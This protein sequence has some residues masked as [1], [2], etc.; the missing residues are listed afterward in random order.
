MAASNAKGK[1][2]NPVSGETSRCLAMVFLVSLFQ[3]VQAY[4]QCPTVPQVHSGQATFYTFADG[5]GACMF[6]PT[7]NDLLVGAMNAIDY[8]TSQVCGECVSLTG[9]HAT[10]LIRIVDLCPECAQGNIDLSP[11]AFSQ[12]ADTILGKVP[13]TWQVV[14]CTVPGPIQYQFNDSSS[15]WWT[16]V[17]IRNHRYPILSLE[18]RDAGGTYHP[19]NRTNYNYFVQSPGIGQG[20]YTFRVTDVYGHV[21]EDSGIPLVVGG[22]VSGHAQFP[23]C[24]NAT[25]V[26]EQVSGGGVPAVFE[27]EQNYPNPFNPSTVVSWQLSGVSAVK[28]SIHDLLGREIAVL[29]EGEQSPGRYSVQWNATG[30]PGGVYFAHLRA[31]N[32]FST[33]KMVLLR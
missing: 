18:Y 30:L 5:G 31:G 28:L 32:L 9:P 19:I 6:D 21:L 12:I 13:I 16:A 3:V 17:Q 33:R 29:V 11:L 22:T 2:M 23:L 10:I 24:D 8:N 20:P 7:P 15:Q 1:G 25:A 27:M 26:Q 4:A 14:P